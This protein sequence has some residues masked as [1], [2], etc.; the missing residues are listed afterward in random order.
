VNKCLFWIAALAVATLGF[1]EPARADGTGDEEDP[2][3]L[4]I[5]SPNCAPGVCS[6]LGNHTLNV[7]GHNSMRITFNEANGDPKWPAL[8][9]GPVLLIL[10]IPNVSSTF[11]PPS[12]TLS[13]G[14]GQ[15]GGP[16]VFPSTTSKWDSNGFAGFYTGAFL[17]PKGPSSVYSFIGLINSANAS[18]NFGNM[19]SADLKVNAITAGG[20]GIVVYELTGTDLQGGSTLTINFSSA[21]P[22]GTF[23]FA[24]GCSSLSGGKLGA[25]PGQNTFSTPWTQAGLVVPEPASLILLGSGLLAVGALR[26]KQKKQ[27]E[28]EA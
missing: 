21:L 25:C 27:A 1:A 3:K 5:S 12:L 4:F 8:K 10:A 7:L 16:K 9:G 19:S 11:V 13:Q 26:R 20:F 24:Y 28:P 15:A 6:L 22:A 17:P 23:A 14:T 18:N 2:P